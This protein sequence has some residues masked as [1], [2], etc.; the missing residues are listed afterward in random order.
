MVLTPL[1][2][3]GPFSA[4][5]ASAATAQRVEPSLGRALTARMAALFHDLTLDS[6]PGAERLFFPRSAYVKLK[7]ISSPA[8]DYAQRLIGMFRLD[9]ASYHAT[10]V[11][12]GPSTFLGLNVDRADAAWIEPG[13]C[14]NLIGYWHLPG[15]RLVYRQDHVV[16]SVAVASLISWRGVW[17]VVHLG[18]NPQVRDVGTLDA[19]SVGRG[20]PGPAGGC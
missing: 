16:R 19:P 3:V 6:L 4:A 7:H 8:A 18:P 1:A 14:E 5:R 10:F 13:W 20:V 15:V 2:L 17:Y 9:V 11:D 12:A